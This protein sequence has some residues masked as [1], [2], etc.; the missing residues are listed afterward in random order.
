V[1]TISPAAASV[2]LRSDVV[3][4]VHGGADLLLDAYLPVDDRVHAAVVLI[5]GGRWAYGDKEDLAPLAFALVDKGYAA[6][7]VN[8]RL[9][10][11]WPYPAALQD[12]RAA[13]AYVRE[14]AS[15]LRI[16]PARIGALGGSAGGYLAAALAT[17]GEGPLTAGSRVAAAASWSGPLDL[18]ALLP[19][20]DSGIGATIAEFLGCQGSESCPD[21]AREASP[22]ERVSAGDAPLFIANATEERIP[23]TQAVSMARA[24]EGAGIPF[25]LVTPAS[26]DHGI[27]NEADLLE[28]TTDFFERWLGQTATTSD[29]DDNRPP[30]ST[31]P[32]VP[33]PTPVTGTPSPA[34]T[35]VRI[36]RPI[37]AM[38]VSLSIVLI[39]GTVMLLAAARKA[40][41]AS[42]KDAPRR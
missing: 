39:A 26:S 14:H 2:R 35:D 1:T 11:D 7:T 18:E 10:P 9:L 13:V 38:F 41:R 4:A 6:I 29:S 21:L 33:V 22:V 24:Y 30:V 37:A 16:D 5:H 17:F 42:R 12:V 20:E 19:I 25:E 27:R 8:Y 31:G 34:G 3:Y 28:P 36:G 40:S 23:V 32:G 15:E